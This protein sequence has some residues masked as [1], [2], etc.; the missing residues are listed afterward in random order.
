[1]KLFISACS[2][3]YNRAK[4]VEFIVIATKTLALHTDIVNKVIAGSVITRMIVHHPQIA[5]S[6]NDANTRTCWF[7]TVDSLCQLLLSKCHH[8]F[9]SSEWDPVELPK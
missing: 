7:T 6:R 2:F 3:A 1:M 5:A 8:D 4:H 9:D